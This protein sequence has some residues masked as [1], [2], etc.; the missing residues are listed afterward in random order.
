[1]A[2]ALQNTNVSAVKDGEASI[3]QRTYVPMIAQHGADA[4]MALAS[5]RM[6]GLDQIALRHSVGTTAVVMVSATWIV[7]NIWVEIWVLNCSANVN[8]VGEVSVVI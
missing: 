3:A 8:M 5:V 4:S 7:S 1:M 2:S 6:D